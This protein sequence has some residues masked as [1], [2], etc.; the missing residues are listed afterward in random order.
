[1]IEAQADYVNVSLR[2]GCG[3]NGLA[4]GLMTRLDRQV[5]ELAAAR[6]TQMTPREVFLKDERET[7][8]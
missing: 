3:V 8:S 5:T 6:P 4:R 2:K 7:D 1:M